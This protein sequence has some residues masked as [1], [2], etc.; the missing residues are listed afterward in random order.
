MLTTTGLLSTKSALFI[1]G[2]TMNSLESID[3]CLSAREV[4]RVETFAK[5]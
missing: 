2:M 5:R 4:N 1:V 3:K